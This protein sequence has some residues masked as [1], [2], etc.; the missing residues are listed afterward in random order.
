MSPGGSSST[1]LTNTPSFGVVTSDGNQLP[2]VHT[3]GCRFEHRVTIRALLKKTIGKASGDGK[4]WKPALN[5]RFGITTLAPSSDTR[6][7]PG[8]GGA[9]V[10]VPCVAGE[11][12]RG[13]LLDVAV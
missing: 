1:Q 6:S 13:A 7:L 4:P 3:C 12:V 5:H 8:F 9:L 2:L 10:S 11:T